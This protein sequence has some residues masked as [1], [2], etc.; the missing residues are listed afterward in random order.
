MALRRW[1]GVGF[2]FATLF[3][4]TLT[5]TNVAHATSLTS[6]LVAP[7]PGPNDPCINCVEFSQGAKCEISSSPAGYNCRDEEHCVLWVFCGWSCQTDPGP[8]WCDPNYQFPIGPGGDDDAA[9]VG[10]DGSLANLILGDSDEDS[11]LRDCRG[12]VLGRSYALG[13]AKALRASTARITL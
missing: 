3:G 1:L 8:Q 11:V 10:A 9:V 2:V 6:T 13:T 4:T 12:R 7:A 5:T